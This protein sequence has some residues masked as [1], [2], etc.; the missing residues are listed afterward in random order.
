MRSILNVKC[1]DLTKILDKQFAGIQSIVVGH[2]PHNSRDFDD[3]RLCDGR[4]ID[5]D[6]GMSR[7][8]KGD[9]GHVAAL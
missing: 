2:V 3:W 6:F 4:L 5:V 1:R 7:W 9:P 8:K